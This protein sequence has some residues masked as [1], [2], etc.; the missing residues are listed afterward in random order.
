M[1]ELFN[2]WFFMDIHICDEAQLRNHE[3]NS[4]LIFHNIRHVFCCFK[5]KSYP[6]NASGFKEFLRKITLRKMLTV[7][8]IVLIFL[9]LGCIRG[10]ETQV[11]LWEQRTCCWY[12]Y[13][14]SMSRQEKERWRFQLLSLIFSYCIFYPESSQEI[15][16][17][18]YYISKFSSK[19]YNL[20]IFS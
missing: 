11:I 1:V 8:L 6:F 13:I 14:N 9:W 16:C 4:S 5:L 18:T 19:M 7:F 3:F 20:L 2:S 12:D 10:E 17:L 15:S